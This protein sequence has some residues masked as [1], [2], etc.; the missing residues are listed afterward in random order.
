MAGDRPNA[1]RRCGG[2]RLAVRVL[3]G[4]LGTLAA[5]A[6]A[7]YALAPPPPPPGS[8]SPTGS[9]TVQRPD[10]TATRLPDGRVF[11]AGGMAGEVTTE[12]FSP[13]PGTWAVGGNLG[14]ARSGHTAT[15]LKDGR[16]LLAG[17]NGATSELYDPATGEL[18]PTGMMTVARGGVGMV[19][20]RLADGRVL[21]VGGEPGASAEIYDPAASDPASGLKGR[22]TATGSIHT[23]SLTGSTL[24]TLQDGRVLLAG[25]VP[26]IGGPFTTDTAELY[27]PSTGTW[28]LTGKLNTSRAGH[29]ATLLPNGKVLIAGGKFVEFPTFVT[30]FLASAELYDPATGTWTLTG[31]MGTPRGGFSPQRPSAA[32]LTGGKVLV[33]GGRLSQ[34]NS[35]LNAEV[36]DSASGTWAPT[37]NAPVSDHLGSTATRLLDGRVLVA[38]G[39]GAPTA[40]DIYDPTSDS[41]S[42]TADLV[43]P[44]E[45][46]TASLLPDGKVLVRGGGSGLATAEEIF[47]PASGTWTA[48]GPRGGGRSA[49]SATLLGDGKVLIAGGVSGD[50]TTLDTA[51]LYDPATGF[52]RNTAPMLTP[53]SH[54][55]E[56]R[57]ASGKVLVAGGLGSSGTPLAS[58]ELYDPASE[59]WSA[60]GT[61]GARSGHT[62]SLLP[63]GKV[64]VAGGLGS[65]GSPTD[66]AEL[67]D[68][69]SNSWSPVAPLPGA[70]SGHTATTLADGRVLV[71]GGKAADGTPLG[72]AELF[73]PANTWTAAQALDTPRT[74]HTATLL[75][76][77]KVLVAGG[78]GAGASQLD[79]AELY[80][81]V[82]DSWGATDALFRPRSGHLAT[83]LA[84]GRVLALGP[85]QSAEI[86]DPITVPKA[87]FQATGSLSDPHS[88]H[89]ETVLPSGKVLV[90]GGDDAPQSAELYNPRSG[91]WSRAATP[92]GPHAGHVAVLLANGKVLVA[93]GG[94]NAAEIYD[95]ATNS[96]SS[97]GSMADARALF[98]A[99]RLEDGRV[100]VVGGTGFGSTSAEVYDPAT[101]LWTAT[102]PTLATRDP[103]SATATLL[104]GAGCGGNCGKVLIAGSDSFAGRSVLELY[105]PAAN[106]FEAPGGPLLT[107]PRTLPTAT[108]LL[109]G[110]VLI[111]TGRNTSAS[112]LIDPATLDSRA[113]GPVNA[114]ILNNAA[115]LLPNGE[116][117]EVGGTI[118]DFNL[119]DFVTSSAELFDPLDSRWRYTR[120]MTTPR[121]FLTA[122]VLPAG[123]VSACGENCGKV[124]VVGGAGSVDSATSAELYTPQPQVTSV[125]PAAAPLSGGTEVTI[126]GHGLAA[127]SRV[128]FGDSVAASAIPDAQTPDSKLTVI[129]PPH[130]A[131]T[132]DVRVGSVGGISDAGAA[133]RFTYAPAATPAAGAAAAVSPA[134]QTPAIA[135]DATAPAL[136]ALR[137][138]RHRFRRGSR[139]PRAAG[140]I[141]VGTT[142]SFTLSEPAT[143]SFAF[144]RATRCRAAKAG[145]A[146]RRY[147]AASSPLRVG[148][149]AGI[150]RLRFDGRLSARRSLRIGSY[151]LTAHATDAAGNRSS[152]RRA[153]FVLVGAAR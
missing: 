6:G 60:A 91:R 58:A 115:V 3:S 128:S 44:R 34:N 37:A 74:G 89:S 149:R 53:R 87:S 12:L 116:V 80:D 8:W 16:I 140:A 65:D 110:R 25:G 114:Q 88:H 17:G 50:G 118:S 61:L 143:V 10:G 93:G 9:P 139:L 7:A 105:D 81:P 150:N 59:S 49:Q 138:S 96:W 151:R 56:T 109:D 70:R 129:A 21:V 135:R 78:T 72:S 152:K 146:C 41:W 95:P 112:E 28:T 1:E 127:V 141:A 40:A 125:T 104:T 48:F 133:D 68:P 19:A 134:A 92:K 121:R 83:L 36:Y 132:V 46:H 38:G 90:V 45:L 30:Q 86:Y 79:S 136:G 82:G 123:P 62:A 4:M 18:Q 5:I 73:G 145:S 29:I 20:A 137:L 147:V 22:W 103:D 66:S 99:A 11:T 108:R 97:T 107:V 111:A 35:A 67:Y 85:D 47:D 63:S 55:T 122:A 102:G 101:G 26:T 57:L 120:N 126:T 15:T 23:L 148:G 43:Y 54:Q 51:E 31:A 117:L 84:D 77:G 2:P 71:A 27:D 113:A 69:S 13:A 98:P 75:P 94:T 153:T 131:G 119:G 32:A 64:L 76:G 42:P 52:V 106:A 39:L 14:D 142:I 144:A 33:V 24:T 124:L 130:V 100:L